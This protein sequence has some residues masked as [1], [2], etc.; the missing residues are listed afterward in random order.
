MRID[1]EAVGR[2]VAAKLA[3]AREHVAD[4]EREASTFISASLEAVR[5]VENSGRRHVVYWTKYSEP[6][7]KLGLIMGDAAHNARSALDH[8]VWALATS[9]AGDQGIELTDE[10]KR[11]LQFPTATTGKDF[12]NNKDKFLKGVPDDAVN[13]I[14]GRQPFT[15]K[16]Y[17][18]ETH[19]LARLS[20]LDNTDKHR[21]LVPFV[22]NPA[23]SMLDWP[24]DASDVNSTQSDQR[25]KEAGVEIFRFDF[26]RPYSAEELPMSFPF[27]IGIMAGRHYGGAASLLSHLIDQVDALIDD[28]YLGAKITGSLIFYPAEQTG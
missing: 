21:T 17:E 9:G 28:I 18:P 14:K 25:V 10:D 7:D 12:R 4:L 1:A 26:P 19:F 24:K 11:W 15:I 20:R 22:V 23:I 5:T 3:R 8:L 27:Q 6:P 2:S 13:Y 16:P